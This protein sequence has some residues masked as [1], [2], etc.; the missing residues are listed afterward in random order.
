MRNRVSDQFAGNSN[1]VSYLDSNDNRNTVIV[2][3]EL[4]VVNV[5]NEWQERLS[6]QLLVKISFNVLSVSV[7]ITVVVLMIILTKGRWNASN[8]GG[9]DATNK[10]SSSLDAVA[11]T[12]PPN[13]QVTDFVLV[14]GYHLTQN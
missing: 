13:V 9:K 5:P 14:T 3:G 7:V 11:S 6:S 8:S 4:V 10:Q 2:C 12:P 1:N